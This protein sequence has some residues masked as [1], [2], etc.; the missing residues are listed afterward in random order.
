MTP[1]EVIRTLKRLA[2]NPYDFLA[3]K[4]VE[5]AIKAL[6]KQ[7]PKKIEYVSDGDAEDSL[8]CEY[9]CPVCEEELYRCNYYAY[10]PYCGQAI[11]WDDMDCEEEQE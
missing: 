3:R 6:E 5:E 1:A 4:A 10:C 11:D 9:R 8:V 2:P 7:V